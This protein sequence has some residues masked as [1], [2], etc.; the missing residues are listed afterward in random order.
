M[1]V[2]TPATGPTKASAGAGPE[3]AS[4]APP[5]EIPRSPTEKPLSRKP[6]SLGKKLARWAIGPGS[7]LDRLTSIAFGI[8]DRTLAPQLLA[9]PQS[10]EKPLTPPSVPV[11]PD[12]VSTTARPAPEGGQPRAPEKVKSAEEQTLDQALELDMNV[13]LIMGEAAKA[14]ATAH[15]QL[16]QSMVESG[17][18]DPQKLIEAVHHGKRHPE[19]ENALKAK[20]TTNTEFAKKLQAA[21]GAEEQQRE[22]AYAAVG[23]KIGPNKEV[24]AESGGK[25]AALEAKLNAIDSSLPNAQELRTKVW[26]EAFLTDPVL[27]KTLALHRSQDLPDA[28]AV[29]QADIRNEEKANIEATNAEINRLFDSFRKLPVV[30]SEQSNLV[31][32]PQIRRAA[33]R[34]VGYFH[35]AEQLGKIEAIT[36][37]ALVL[38][39]AQLA[40]REAIFQLES[41]QLAQEVRQHHSS[42]NDARL[43][44]ERRLKT[45]SEEP[46]GD[47]SEKKVVQEREYKKLTNARSLLTKIEAQINMEPPQPN[48]TPDQK[49]QRIASRQ[50]EVLGSTV[51]V[52][53]SNV[54]SAKV[55][56]QQPEAAFAAALSRVPQKENNQFFQYL[57]NLP[58]IL[59]RY[60]HMAQQL[61]QLTKIGIRKKRLRPLLITLIVLGIGASP[62]MDEFQRMFKIQ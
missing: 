58:D 4:M 33:E 27:V 39:R 2:V 56:L 30:Q 10:P 14:G 44:I 28:V 18:K 37:S 20:A 31:N 55:N 32:D 46:T 8:K 47:D 53:E 19:I 41:V 51:E 38:S 24:Q 1:P 40:H 43:E 12:V 22:K 49:A 35:A 36:E 16:I 42:L 13:D 11:D 54:A 45:I 17:S 48:E 3:S 57:T 59:Q 23:I 5:T 9:S 21:Q 34:F 50:Q 26:Q 25:Y 60:P 6:D 29:V 15:E 7:P 52:A 62:L 61:E